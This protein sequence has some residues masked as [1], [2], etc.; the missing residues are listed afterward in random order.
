MIANIKQAF[1]S[2]PQKP[3]RRQKGSTLP[4]RYGLIILGS[5]LLMFAGSSR[6]Y[7]ATAGVVKPQVALV[8]LASFAGVLSL[9]VAAAPLRA[10]A[11]WRRWY[12][13]LMYPLCA[14]AVFLIL[15]TLV[16]FAGTLNL[17]LQRSAAQTY[18]NDVISFTQVNAELVLA[19]RNPYVSN[20]AFKM[21][22]EQYP[23]APP[24]P[25]RR[26]VFG[27]G[28][29]PPT[30][31]KVQAVA[32]LYLTDPAATHGALD[33]RTL[34][35][36]PALSF[37]FYVPFV[38]A[39]LPNILLLSLLICMGVLVWVAWQAPRE[40]RLLALFTAGTAF[41]IVYSLPVDTEI[42]CVAL[43]LAAWHLRR[44]KWLAP[45]LLGLACAFKQYSWFF[46]PYFIL[47]VWL[48]QGGSTALRWCGVALGTFLLPN[49]PY[50]IMSPG[51]WVQ[52]LLLP[53]SEP[54]FP[55]GIGIMT[56]SLGHL[57][58]YAPPI[59][60]AVC[61]LLVLA[62]LPALVLWLQRRRGISLG[63]AVLIVALVPLLFAFRSPP[64]YFAFAPWL[65]LYAANRIYVLRLQSPL[66]SDSVA[67]KKVGVL[68]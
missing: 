50:L 63:G 5:G 68:A 56:L 21:A 18:G 6:V 2:P 54:L 46:V 55:Q 49:L 12:R 25:L 59:F 37:L 4:P 15:G 33:P 1:S 41:C 51:A 9:I 57:V 26:G 17:A 20:M 31:A 16:T 7:T 45:V 14:A 61:E 66:M 64:N 30:I 36:Y 13:L 24:T 11:P 32:H 39:G 22:L 28:Y 65:A 19:S 35:S 29:D 67:D 43:L 42:V 52:S 40:W 58:P 48:T 10:P 47:E 34:H 8:L 27:T 62:A 3:R 60:Y 38:W 53:I 44:R 23:E